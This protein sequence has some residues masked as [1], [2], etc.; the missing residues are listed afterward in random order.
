MEQDRKIDLIGVKELEIKM[1][2]C[3]MDMSFTVFDENWSDDG[4]S[5]L[6]GAFDADRNQ[7]LEWLDTRNE[8]NTCNQ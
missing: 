4:Q 8:D 7:H 3:N 6:I 1:L 2:I 5:V